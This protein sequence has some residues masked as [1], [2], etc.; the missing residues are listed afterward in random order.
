MWGHERLWK[1]QGGDGKSLGVLD[2]DHRVGPGRRREVRERS[3]SI[4]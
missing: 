2:E 3:E 1:T 4:M